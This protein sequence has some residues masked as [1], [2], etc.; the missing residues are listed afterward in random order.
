MR[1]QQE[2]HETLINSQSIDLAWSSF[3]KFVVPK[4]AGAIQRA[5]T[6]TAFYAGVDWYYQ[7]VL[8][9]CDDEKG[10]MRFLEGVAK[11]LIAFRTELEN[12]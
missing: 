10:A 2:L 5:E 11:E 3:D 7:R 1:R 4:N 6:R 8:A 12:K 9:A